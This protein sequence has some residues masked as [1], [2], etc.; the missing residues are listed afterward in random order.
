MLDSIAS[1][2]RGN[3]ILTLFV[4]IGIGF[5]IGRIKVFGFSLG[6][7]AFL[8]FGILVSALVPRLEFPEFAYSFGLVIFV[9]TI[10]L[11]SGPTFFSSLRRQGVKTNILAL[12]ALLSGAI[13]TLL[14]GKAIGI[15]IPEI[16]GT[17][18]GAL[19]NTPALAAVIEAVP[20]VLT[21]I[22]STITVADIRSQVVVGYSLA[23]PLGVLGVIG[24]FQLAINLFHVD[25]E[26]EA[27]ESGRNYGKGEQEIMVRNYHV[28]NPGIAGK[29]AA[30]ILNIF[31]AQKNGQCA[32][33]R[34]ERK[35][36]TS[37]VSPETVLE[38]GDILTVVAYSPAHDLIQS[39]LG[40]V[41]EKRLEKDTRALSSVH[42]IVSNRSLTGKLISQI[43]ILDETA[44]LTRL[45]RGDVE[46]VPN[47]FTTLEMG[48]RIRVVTYKDH[49]EEVTK[50]FG[51]AINSL[52]ET[53]FLSV[54]LGVSLGILLGLIPIP[55]PTGGVFK[56]GLAGGPLV[57]AL[58]LGWRGRTGP[59]RWSL[60]SNTNHVLREVGLVLFLAGIGI[61]TG[62]QFAS[63]LSSGNGLTL[64]LTGAAVTFAVAFSVLFIGYKV[65]KM[66]FAAVMGVMSAVQTQPAC[67]AFANE[68]A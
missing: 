14:L 29:K 33:S 12:I 34:L 42:L 55:L 38:Y 66:P 2:L 54:S 65:L 27:R 9:Y 22:G 60:P 26:P 46:L 35:G 44:T 63:V 49:I 68:K 7:S 17:F 57:I 16:A 67:L 3:I 48:D 64:L 13:L 53:D 5:M 21:K 52:A 56:L 6:V 62:N 4:V 41:S 11:Q 23:Y 15:N 28:V 40:Q 24:A 61:R 20:D 59:I 43:P 36:E 45:R 25:F 58:I 51:N 1:V 8:F 32:L 30:I 50:F 18:C 37:I 31:S 47:P 10:G 39:L 19:T